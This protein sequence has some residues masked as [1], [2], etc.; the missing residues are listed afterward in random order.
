MSGPRRNLSANSATAP[1]FRIVT[2][3]DD[4]FPNVRVPRHPYPVILM[5]VIALAVSLMLNRSVLGRHIY[6]VGSNAEAARLS[7]V[8]VS[9]VTCFTYVPLRHA[10]PASPAAC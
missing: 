3:G 9:G 10:S 4:G 7:G 6:A 2:I 1:L 5:V 8:N